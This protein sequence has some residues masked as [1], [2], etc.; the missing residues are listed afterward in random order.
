MIVRHPQVRDHFLL[1]DRHESFGD[2]ARAYGDALAEHYESN[3]VIVVPHV[4]IAF[5]REFFQGLRVPQE[6]KKIGTVNGIEQPLVVRSGGALAIAEDHPLIVGFG[7]STVAIYAQEQI[8]S[9]NAQLRHGLG[10][11][12]PRYFSLREGNI[13]WRLTRTVEE[14]L[15]FDVFQGGAPLA[16]IGKSLHRVKLFINIDDEP[17]QWRTS[18]DMPTALRVGRGLLPEELPD[19]VNVVC[20]LIGKIGLLKTLPAHALAYPTMAAVIV[21]G[22]TLAHEVVYGRRVVA[23]EFLCTGGDMLS[24]DKLSHRCLPGWLREAGYRVTADAAAIA[25]K[26]AHVKSSYAPDIAGRNGAAPA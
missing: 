4:P 16:P 2:Y 12:F 6:W 10:Q 1:L 17:R 5:D 14:G 8:A 22:E 26:Y 18:H 7:Q 15:H 11:L 23:G 21:N 25:A 20:D 13:T 3:G 19:D 24:P 9:F